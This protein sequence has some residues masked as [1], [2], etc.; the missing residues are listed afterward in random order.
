MDSGPP[1]NGLRLLKPAGQPDR[2]VLVQQR[3]SALNLT[4]CIFVPN[5]KGLAICPPMEM[6]L[7]FIQC[8]N[9]LVVIVISVA[10]TPFQVLSFM[11]VDGITCA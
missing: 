5:N 2:Q 3:I 11:I 10:A 7:E 6:L 1:G 4:A 8:F 9:L